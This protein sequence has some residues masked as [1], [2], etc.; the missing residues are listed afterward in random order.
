MLVKALRFYSKV[1]LG[2]QATFRLT[3]TNA[4]QLLLQGVLSKYRL[5]KKLQKPSI[6]NLQLTKPNIFNLI[7]MGAVQK[8]KDL[9]KARTNYPMKLK[10]P[11]V[12]QLLMVAAIRNFNLLKKKQQFIPELKLTKS[13]GIKLLFLGAIK[14]YYKIWNSDI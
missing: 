12:K 5:H 11:N 3:K 13:N 7:M 10:A 14:A 1:R 6:I 2:K 8:Y 9:F 4:M